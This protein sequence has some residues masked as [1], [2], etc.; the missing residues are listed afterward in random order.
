MRVPTENV[1]RIGAID[2][3]T[4]ADGAR[5]AR[6]LVPYGGF[7]AGRPA[8]RARPCWSTAPPAP[9]AA[10]ASPSA[11][12]MG[13]GRVVAT[14]RNEQALDRPER[15]FGDRV[16][17]VR[18]PVDEEEDRQAI[19]KARRRPIDCVLD[20]LPPMASPAWCGRPSGGC[21]PMAAPS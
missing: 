7:V 20:L 6:L 9:S 14:G 4:P 5:S 12:A 8:G 11:L 18:W 2:P 10:P 13:A 15:R 1:S 17:P 3:P 21:G 19:L 16:R